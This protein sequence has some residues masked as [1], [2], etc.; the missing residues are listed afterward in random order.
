MISLSSVSS[1]KGM[2]VEVASVLI[3]T[4]S[5]LLPDKNDFKY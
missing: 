5:I 3:V 1:T 4:N 2:V